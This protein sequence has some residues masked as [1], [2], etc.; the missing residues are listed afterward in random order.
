MAENYKIPLTSKQVNEI[1]DRMNQNQRDFIANSV[2]QNKKSKWLETLAHRKGIFISEGMSQSKIEDMLND[3][4]LKD[5]KDCGFGNRDYHCECGQSLRFQ[6]IV[7]HTGQNKTYELGSTCFENYTKLSPGII[8]DIKKGFHH[9][10]LERDEILIKWIKGETDD[11][12]LYIKLN[13]SIPDEIVE[14]NSL[15]LPLLDKQWNVIDMLFQKYEDQRKIAEENKRLQQ[16]K[17]KQKKWGIYNNNKKP[18]NK[19]PLEISPFE[20]SKNYSEGKPIQLPSGSNQKSELDYNYIM[21]SYIAILKEIRKK[22]DKLPEGLKNCWIDTQNSLRSLKKCKEFSY[23]KFR[24]SL[25][26]LCAYLRI[27]FDISMV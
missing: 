17:E 12:S 16:L 14:Q 4:L 6:Y 5:I 10:D 22:E 9:I 21:S 1:L 26:K 13:I 3:W 23:P 18:I 7:Y 27:K 11:L 20:Y 19:I 15:G 25:L 24:I 8:T 2:V